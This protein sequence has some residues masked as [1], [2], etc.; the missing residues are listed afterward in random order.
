MVK[1]TRDD[2][3][4]PPFLDLAE[5]VI[6]GAAA[7]ASADLLHIVRIDSWFGDRWYSFAG[8]TRGAVG[9]HSPGTLTVP[10]FH[11]H[12]VVSEARYRRGCP[13]VS[14]PF[15][16]P[17]HGHRSSESNLYHSFGGFGRIWTAPVV[18]GWFSG[19]SAATGH[20]SVMAYTRTRGGTT[21][22]YAGLERRGDWRVVKLVGVDPR[23]WSMLL[24]GDPV[25]PRS[26][27]GSDL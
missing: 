16:D 20:G 22:W 24:A 3:H 4:D 18:G 14:V 19:N 9:V 5:R 25:C 12:R 1:L 17:L 8:K 11:P 2:S 26:A 21:G 27:A 10:P 13:A 15:R 6:N 23:H 7:I